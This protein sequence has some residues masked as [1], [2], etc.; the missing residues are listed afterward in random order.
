MK[1]VGWSD[2]LMSL[3][4][5]FPKGWAAV[6]SRPAFCYMHDF[7]AYDVSAF[8]FFFYE[9]TPKGFYAMASSY[10]SLGSFC[11]WGSLK[12]Q[13]FLLIS[14]L[15]EWIKALA[16]FIS[17]KWD[18]PSVIGGQLESVS[19]YFIRW[20]SIR[21]FSGDGWS[22]YRL[23]IFH[24]CSLFGTIHYFVLFSMCQNKKI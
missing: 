19:K 15:S 9:W 16:R 5:Q 8:F 10:F 14:W 11:D 24:Y 6:W 4:Q 13:L 18:W 1:H 17:H 12:W 3:R 20:R 7:K 21:I 22:T 23:T 2:V